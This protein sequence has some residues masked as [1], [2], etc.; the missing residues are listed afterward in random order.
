LFAM[1][2]LSGLSPG[3]PIACSMEQSRRLEK[4]AVATAY[5][6]LAGDA[7]VLDH[8]PKIMVSKPENPPVEKKSRGTHHVAGLS[9]AVHGK[10]LHCST[11]LAGGRWRSRRRV[12]CVVFPSFS[13]IP[14]SSQRRL[15]ASRYST[16]TQT[17]SKQPSCIC[18]A[19]QSV[20]HYLFSSL[21]V[22][23]STRTFRRLTLTSGYFWFF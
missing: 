14:S 19:S 20:L 6:K 3:R 16:R 11:P 18:T 2:R 10:L 15:S 23:L 4:V 5:E 17:R 8:G 13:S 1:I 9:H 21:L 22:S 7:G 12:K